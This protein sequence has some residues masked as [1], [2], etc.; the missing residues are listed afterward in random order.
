MA[1]NGQLRNSSDG[2]VLHW[3][4]RVVSAEELR[5]TLNGQRELIV[6]TAAIITPSAAEHLRQSGVRITRKDPE[7]KPAAAATWGYAEDRPVPFVR[8][9]VQSLARDGIELRELACPNGQ[10][11]C[12]WARTAADCV[13]R[14][15][16]HGA[17]VFC[18]DAG[19]LC[20]VANK[21]PG[22][23]ATAVRSPA[24]VNRATRALGANVVAVETPG[25]T[26]FEIRQ[27]LRAV[28]GAGAPTC[29][30]DVAT[31]LQECDGHAH[32]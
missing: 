13:A 9:A 25:P 16:C 15:E 2:P 28:C 12:Q 1:E 19:L 29:P 27:I 4:G 20:C 26:F 14:G 30:L 7:P 21:I 22:L 10:E 8:S 31:A 17:I 18:E 3:P 5:R 11:A 23:R 24:Q 32:R 6:P